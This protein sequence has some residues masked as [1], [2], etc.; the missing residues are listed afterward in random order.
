MENDKESFA[1]NTQ[2]TP[3][4]IPGPESQSTPSPMPQPTPNPELAPN[5]TPQPSPSPIAQPT[6]TSDLAPNQAVTQPQPQPVIPESDP[7]PNIPVRPAKQPMSKSLITLIIIAAALVVCTVVAIVIIS[8][9]GTKS[10]N[11]SSNNSS[12]SQTSEDFTASYN[13]ANQTA[14][15][16]ITKSGKY[17]LTGE[18]NEY[19]VIINADG[20]VT[21][22]LNNVTISAT[23]MAAIANISPN[24]LTIELADGTTNK[25]SDGGASDYDGCIYST[26]ALIINGKTGTLNVEGRQNEGEGIAT[27]SSDM[28]INGGSINI[29]SVDDGL[30]AGGDGGTITI[31]GGDIFIQAGGDGIDSNKD[32]VINGGSIYAAGSSEGGNAGID[33]DEGYS[34]NGGTVVAFGADMLEKPSD[35]SKQNTLVIALDKSY[36][37]SAKVVLENSDGE[38]L[39]EATAPNSFKTLIFS[40]DG[41]GYGIY[42]LTV[43]G[44]TVADSLNVM[45]TITTYGNVDQQPAENQGGENPPN[46]AP[47]D[48]TQANAQTNSDQVLTNGT[49]TYGRIPLSEIPVDE[50]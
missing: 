12:S 48:N 33:T 16:E 18:M 39:L 10:S 15:L 19:S 44:E 29:Y 2:E 46:E 4:T 17:E 23:Q 32:L 43:N 7:M 20:P 21:L 27:E 22:Y 13:L 5:P 26:G 35:S 30:N 1:S 41:L 50:N 6:S 8:N 14:N 40:S 9:T 36:D 34:I 31:N 38:S 42:K 37:V 11:N 49:D 47:A 28:T 24:S 25:L 3:N 45:N